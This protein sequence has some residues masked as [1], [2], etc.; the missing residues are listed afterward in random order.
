MFTLP[1]GVLGTRILREAA[2]GVNSRRVIVLA[3]CVSDRGRVACDI[4]S[5][6]FNGVADS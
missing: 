1:S 6:G 3:Y 5:V 2:M 4:L